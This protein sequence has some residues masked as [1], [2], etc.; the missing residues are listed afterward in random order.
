[1]VLVLAIHY[2]L[3]VNAFDCVSLL[4]IHVYVIYVSLW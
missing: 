1:M 2:A 3:H 4:I